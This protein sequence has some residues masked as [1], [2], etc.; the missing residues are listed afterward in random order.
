M[1]GPESDEPVVAGVDFATVAEDGRLSE[2]TGFLE[3]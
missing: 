2:V 1:Y 3:S